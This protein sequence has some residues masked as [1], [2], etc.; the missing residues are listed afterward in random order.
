LTL[1]VGSLGG[2][3]IALLSRREALASCLNHQLLFLEHMHEL[4]PN[5]GVLG[6]LQ[7]FE[8]QHGTRHPLDGSMVLL[9]QIIEILHLA[10]DERGAMLFVI[11]LDGDCIGLTAVNGDL[12]RPARTAD[13]LPQKPQR[14]L[15]SALLRQ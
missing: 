7:R 6:R 4:N 1:L 13:R 9:H 15:L 10:D 8:P 3:G 5:R 12:L 11:A 2:Q 14:R